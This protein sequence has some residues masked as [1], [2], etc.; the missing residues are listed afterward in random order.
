M[1]LLLNLCNG[2][3]PPGTEP[4]PSAV[5]AGNLNHWTSREANS[6]V[7]FIKEI[8]IQ[9]H[10]TKYEGTKTCILHFTFSFFA[11]S[12]LLLLISCP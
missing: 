7:V 8:W 12:F 10:L 11:S 4:S 5:E 9:K 1:L 2:T 3:A 6:L